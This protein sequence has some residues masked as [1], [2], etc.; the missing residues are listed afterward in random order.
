M[1]LEELGFYSDFIDK[2]RLQYLV[3]IA[4]KLYSDWVGQ[5]RL[6]S[7]R[8]FIVRY[9]YKEMS[10]DSDL[11]LHFDNAEVTLNVSLNK[12]FI[13]GELFFGNIKTVSAENVYLFF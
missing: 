10:D 12:D 9:D 8:A 6:D 13:G 1:L 7:Q 5:S 2:L 11:R 3:P 4:S